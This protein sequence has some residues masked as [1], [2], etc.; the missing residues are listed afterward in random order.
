[1]YCISNENNSVCCT[2]CLLLYAFGNVKIHLATC[3]MCD[4]EIRDIN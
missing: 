1:M 3:R 2:Y 4:N